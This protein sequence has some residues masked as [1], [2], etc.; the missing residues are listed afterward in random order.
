MF[1][2]CLR[3]DCERGSKRES[4]KGI[5]FGWFNRTAPVW[6]KRLRDGGCGQGL[7]TDIAEE[8][9]SVCLAQSDRSGLERKIAR[10]EECGWELRT[11]IAFVWFSHMRAHSRAHV[12]ICRE[13]LMQLLELEV[14]AGHSLTS[15]APVCE[16]LFRNPF[17]R[18]SNAGS[19]ACAGTCVWC[20]SV[21]LA[22]VCMF[23]PRTCVWRMRTHVASVRMCLFACGT[24]WFMR[25]AF[26]GEGLLLE[27][28]CFRKSLALENA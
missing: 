5:L 2:K 15:H 13:L 9:V 19:C 20:M 21:C 8:D 23:G 16:I 18:F 26:S 1:S 28:T 22:R 12:S 25:V 24:V 27:K 14:S 6:K 17:S 7:Q 10:W 4:R 11:S 3:G